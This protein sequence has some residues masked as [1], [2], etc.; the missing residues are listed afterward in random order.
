M[1][2]NANILFF[3]YFVFYFLI[4]DLKINWF[5]PYSKKIREIV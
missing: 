5:F 2:Y 4:L 1:E 3:G